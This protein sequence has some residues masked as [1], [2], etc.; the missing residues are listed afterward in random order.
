MDEMQ[1]KILTRQPS[2]TLVPSAPASSAPLFVCWLL[3]SNRKKLTAISLCHM[4]APQDSS[5]WRLASST[6][7]KT[8]AF[9]KNTSSA[10]LG[11]ALKNQPFH[12]RGGQPRM[13]EP[14]TI[15]L[16]VAKRPRG[17]KR[18]QT[19]RLVTCT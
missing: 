5:A 14:H 16:I 15:D 17:A 18:A 1:H 11:H 4:P 3:H 6:Q 7:T 19:P 2:L 9:V 8:F 10:N 13:T 12:Q